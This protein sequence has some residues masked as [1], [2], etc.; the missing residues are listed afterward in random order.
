MICAFLAVKERIAFVRLC[1]ILNPCTF[2]DKIFMGAIIVSEILLYHEE[3]NTYQEP[4]PP[5]EE[6]KERK[7]RQRKK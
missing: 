4:G 5:P 1:G 7:K 2:K 3:Y 6:I